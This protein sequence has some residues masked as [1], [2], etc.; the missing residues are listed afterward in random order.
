M[1]LFLLIF[2]LGCI[3]SVYIF[4]IFHLTG[5][6]GSG[7][8]SK[9]GSGTRGGKDSSRTTFKTNTKTT[10][11][12]KTKTTTKLHGSTLDWRENHGN[13]PTPEGQKRFHEEQTHVSKD[14]SDLIPQLQHFKDLHK[15]V[16]RGEESK[17]NVFKEF[18]QE[19]R[20]Q[21]EEQY[22]KKG[23][24]VYSPLTSVKKED[25]LDMGYDKAAIAALGNITYAE[26]IKG[27]ER[28]VD[29]L[30]E[31]GIDEI[32]PEVIAVLPKWSAVEHLYGGSP[33]IL[34]LERCEEF[35]E[36]A[37]PIDGSLGIA[38]MFNTGTNPMAMYVSKN[39]KMPNNRK[40]KAGGTRWQVPWGKHR[41]ASEKYTNIPAHEQRT[42]MTN[43]LPVVLVRDPYTWMQSMVRIVST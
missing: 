6:S 17:H 28:L 32:D 23:E 2:L 34:G 30:H 15:V 20:V 9:D 11:K 27:R 35:R 29:I 4:A 42:N 37:D 41:L 26:A 7:S 22:N 13:G 5:D 3:V 8:G 43:V 10:T 24:L 38:G 18:S 19:N 31:A 39:C 40:D 33:V 16:E 25:L 21:L 36:Q 1:W 14:L 12:T